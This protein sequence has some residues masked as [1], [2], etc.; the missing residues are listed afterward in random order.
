LFKQYFKGW[1]FNLQGELKKKRKGISDE[2]VK[3]ELI[4][5]SGDLSKDQYFRKVWLVKESLNLLDQEEAYWHK[6]CHEQWLLK[7]DNNTKYFHKIANGRKRKKY[8]H[9]LG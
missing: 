4:E 7:G 3:L 5:E 9:I 2:L 6:R 8:Y 1:G